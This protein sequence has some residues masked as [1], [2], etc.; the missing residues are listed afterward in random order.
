VQILLAAYRQQREYAQ[1]SA[2]LSSQTKEV[3][4]KG[5]IVET[6]LLQDPYAGVP[7]RVQVALLALVFTSFFDG[8]DVAYAEKNKRTLITAFEKS[9]TLAPVLADAFADIDLSTYLEKLK[10]VIPELQSL[11]QQ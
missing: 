10:S 7:P 5:A 3:I 8:H 4:R 6:F 9:P 2:E 11:C 1:F